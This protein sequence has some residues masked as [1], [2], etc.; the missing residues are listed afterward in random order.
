MPSLR[1]M[2]LHIRSVGNIAQVTRALQTVSA[3]KVRRAQAALNAMRPYADK[4][5]EV[6]DHLSDRRRSIHHPMVRPRPQLRNILAVVVSGD[7]GLAGAYNAGVVREALTRFAGFETPV[8]YVV[9]GRKG[10]D[11][12]QRAGVPIVAEFSRLPA[13]PSYSDV[14]P[15]GRLVI[16]EYSSGQA[17]QVHIIY[18]K[19]VNMIRQEPLAQQLLPI[20]DVSPAATDEAEPPVERAGRAPGYLY[21]PGQAQLL[22]TVIQRLVSLEIYECLLES[23]ASEHAARMATMRS[24]SDNAAELIHDLQLMYNKAR[25]QEITGD[26][27]DIAAGTEALAAQTSPS[28]RSASPG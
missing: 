3:S 19:F 20:P 7:R 26:L 9:V 12:L 17:D 10:R 2:R 1:E 8:H 25:Q 4:A 23:L 13:A 14:S 15:I 24:A 11:M 27:L 6:L 16:D 18:T 22:D 5:L 21:E 28:L